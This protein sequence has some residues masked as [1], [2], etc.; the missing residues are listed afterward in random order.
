MTLD[1]PTKSSLSLTYTPNSTL[2]FTFP[3]GFIFQPFGDLRASSVV[4]L[5]PLT[6]L[7]R[8]RFSRHAHPVVAMMLLPNYCTVPGA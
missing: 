6:R 1:P 7:G 5:Q 3:V 4:S 8:E 2:S